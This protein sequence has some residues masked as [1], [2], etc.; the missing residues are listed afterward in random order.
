M[1]TDVQAADYSATMNYLKAV[2]AVGDH[3]CRQ[4]DGPPQ[5][6]TPMDDFY[7]KG[8]IRPDGRYAHDMYLMQVKKPDELQGSLGTTDQVLADL[9]C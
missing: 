8:V 3:R 7:G 6:S 2:E 5:E 1:P 9:A 4:G